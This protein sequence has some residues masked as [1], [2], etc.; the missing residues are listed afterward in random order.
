MEAL[1][2]ETTAELI[3]YAIRLGLLGT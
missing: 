1:E 2:V 3:Q